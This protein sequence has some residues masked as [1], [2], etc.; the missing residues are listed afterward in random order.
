MYYCNRPP[1]PEMESLLKFSNPS[2]ILVSSEYGSEPRIKGS[3]ILP[4]FVDTL[5]LLESILTKL[6]PAGILNGF[7]F[8]FI[9]I[10]S[11]NFLNIGTA[12][13]E[14]VCLYPRK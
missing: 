7:L 11:A 10:F 3:T 4:G 13:L 1:V 9:F 6:I 5:P 14:P 8:L 2:I 12:T